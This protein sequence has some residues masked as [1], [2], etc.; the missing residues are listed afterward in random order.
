MRI[1]KIS[2]KFTRFNRKIREKNLGMKKYV[3]LF[4]WKGRLRGKSKLQV[5]DQGAEISL[6]ALSDEVKKIFQQQKLF[7][8][9][10]QI[11]KT[12]TLNPAWERKKESWQTEWM[13]LNKGN[14]Q[15]HT[16]G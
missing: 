12:C 8:L 1:L 2:G 4:T 14:V 13:L 5:A 16:H 3:P 7:T 10:V 6:K 9:R 15:H 11:P